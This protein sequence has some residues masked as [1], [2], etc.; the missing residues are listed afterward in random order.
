M[1]SFNSQ[2]S[3]CSFFSITK[4]ELAI[5]RSVALQQLQNVVL[6]VLSS[7]P[8]QKR[9]NVCRLKKWKER[10]LKLEK[11]AANITEH[12]SKET[13]LGVAAANTV[14]DE[15]T[16]EETLFSPEDEFALDAT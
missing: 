12:F 11:L 1:Q 6:T 3:E 14:V 16:N 5:H 10:R 8:F 13:V 9:Y 15:K 7:W 2:E 4:H